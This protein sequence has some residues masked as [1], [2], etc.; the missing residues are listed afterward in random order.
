MQG[1][2]GGCEAENEKFAVTLKLGLHLL[3]LFCLFRL[4]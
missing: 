3:R 4:L 1:A 2:I